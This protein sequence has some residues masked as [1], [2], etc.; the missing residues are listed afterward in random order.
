MTAINDRKFSLKIVSLVILATFLFTGASPLFANS[1]PNGYYVADPGKFG[2]WE[3]VGPSGG[4]VRVITIDPRDKNRLYIS[5]LD[6]QIHTSADGGKTWRLLVNF[7]K[8]QLILDQL[9]VDSRDSRIIYA[10]GHRHKMPGGFFKTTD[11]GAT[12]KESKEMRVESIHAMTQSQFDPNTLLA[13]TTDG[14]W[15]SKNSGDDW[16]KIQ[17]GTMPVNIDSLAVDPTNGSTIYAG[18]WWRAYKT[19]DSGKSWRLIKNGMIDDS[20]VFAITINSKNKDHIISSA[21]SGIYESFNGGEKWTKIQGIPSQSR[22]TRDLLQHPSMAG[23]IFAATTEGFWMSS[24]GGKSWAMT[25]QRNLEINSIAVHPEEPN[26]VF[27]GTNNYG[28]MVSNDGGRNFTPTNINF[29][30]R[31]TSQILPDAERPNRV[32]AVTN[33]TTTGGGFFFISDDGGRNWSPTKSLDIA[34]ISPFSVMQDKVNPNLMYLGTNVGIYKSLDRGNSWV[35]VAVAKPVVAKKPVARKGAKP[36]PKPATVAAAAPAPKLVP[37]FTDKVKFLVPTADG[38]NGIFAGTDDGLYRTYDMAKGWEKL[39][40]GAGISPSVFAITAAGDDIWVG[41]ATSG[42]IV[43]HDD[44]KTWARAGGAADGIPISSI[45]VDPKNPNN[46]YVGTSQTFYLS[47]DGGKTWSRRGGN[48]PLG[49]YTSILINP[50]DSNDIYISSALEIDGGIY[51]SE[52]AGMKWKRV[53]SKDMKLPSRRVWTMAFD[54]L[55]PKRIYAG[56]HSSGVYRIERR[57]E[58]A[59]TE[60]AEP[61]LSRPR[62]TME[63]K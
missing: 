47:R 23:T 22:R 46:V 37:G 50:N 53:D 19:T 26:R 3:V 58:T 49:N 8:P 32:Y 17:S 40:F 6:G 7:N 25:S 29:T 31:F 24:N 2:D 54:P 4:D 42:V 21:C 1:N 55:D 27:I 10:S 12:W 39:P 36:A 15:I 45:A 41:T 16:Q 5:T 57:P 9:F 61:G 13:G 44:G 34:R 63:E 62:I 28:V 56:T 38:K 51:H 33:N 35:K 60:T 48:L 14:V 18:T 30:S 11:G 59:S 20:D 43:S 52:D